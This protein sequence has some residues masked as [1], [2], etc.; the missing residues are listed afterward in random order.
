LL[1]DG[2]GDLSTPLIF[3]HH[4]VLAGHKVG[5]GHGRLAFRGQNIR[6]I[7]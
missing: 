3:V 4:N 5:V 1:G 6:L 2:I 7:S